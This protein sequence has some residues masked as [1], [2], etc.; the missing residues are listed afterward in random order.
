MG[1]EVTMQSSVVAFVSSVSL[2]LLRVSAAV[3]TSL[4][5]SYLCLGDIQNCYRENAV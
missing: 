5:I 3:V 4:V 2:S 1:S